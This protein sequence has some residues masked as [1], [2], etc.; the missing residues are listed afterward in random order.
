MKRRLLLGISL[1]LLGGCSSPAQAGPPPANTAA[2]AWMDKICVQ[3]QAGGAQLAKLP[4]I[5]P[6]Q[7]QQAKDAMAGYLGTLADAVTALSNTLTS[8]GAPPVAD[9]RPAVDKA[10]I[11][12]A[13]AK[14]TLDAARTKLQHATVTDPASYA[15]VMNEV[16][17]DISAVTA[18]PGPTVDLRTNNE[19]NEAYGQASSCRKLD[20][21]KS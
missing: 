13:N 18:A 10:M 21:G 12:L 7:P 6:T 19:L 14:T 2:I 8:S 15:R 11:R 16:G 17:T 3:V 1:A 9:G 20:G 5:D 4:K